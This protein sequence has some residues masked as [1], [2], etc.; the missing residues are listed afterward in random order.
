MSFSI[1]LSTTD[2]P[3]Y[4]QW[5]TS[6]RPPP[7]PPSPPS[8]P[9]VSCPGELR[10]HPLLIRAAQQQLSILPWILVCQ[11]RG[12]YGQGPHHQG[13]E[14]KMM[15]SPGPKDAAKLQVIQPGNGWSCWVSGK[16]AC[17]ACKGEAHNNNN[18]F[19]KTSRSWTRFVIQRTRLTFVYRWTKWKLSHNKT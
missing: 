13:G 5:L 14:Q 1:D 18:K 2:E 4:F 19:P 3:G 8:P 15:L 12:S 10:L 16:W 9:A 7:S 17:L 6:W 11:R